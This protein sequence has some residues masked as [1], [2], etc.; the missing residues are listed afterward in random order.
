M[1]LPR[2]FNPFLP[3]EEFDGSSPLLDSHRISIHATLSLPRSPRISPRIEPRRKVQDSLEW[4]V[5][6]LPERST[7][8]ELAIFPIS[9]V[10]LFFSFYL[11]SCLFFSLSNSCDFLGVF[12]PRLVDKL[13]AGEGVLSTYE[14]PSRDIYDRP[15]SLTFPWTWATFALI[16]SPGILRCSYSLFDIAPD[17]SL[18]KSSSHPPSPP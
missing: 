13:T 11:S 7:F 18:L 15:P 8:P 12:P 9:P 1:V 2:P 10:F 4:K 5:F 17:F 3:N 14:S 16:P 6:F